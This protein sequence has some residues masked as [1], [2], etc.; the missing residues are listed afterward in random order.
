[1]TRFAVRRGYLEQFERRI[2]GARIHEEYWIPAE[3]LAEFN[4]NIVGKIEVIA[5]FAATGTDGCADDGKRENA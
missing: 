1:V 5:R 4:S 2:V 3:R